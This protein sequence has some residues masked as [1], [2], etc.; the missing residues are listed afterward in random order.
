[1]CS[2]HRFAESVDANRRGD[3][4]ICESVPTLTFAFASQS[5]WY[6]AP[7]VCEDLPELFMG[8][9]RPYS[10]HDIEEGMKANGCSTAKTS[11]TLQPYR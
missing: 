9:P 4:L 7:A 3:A 10:I 6:T 2:G 11:V 1:M 5:K 8:K